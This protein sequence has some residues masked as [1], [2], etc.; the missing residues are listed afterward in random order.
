MIHEFKIGSAKTQITQGNWDD[1]TGRVT[2]VQDTGECVSL[3]KEHADRFMQIWRDLW[4]ADLNQTKQRLNTLIA[5]EEWSIR[6][7]EMAWNAIGG[8]HHAPLTGEAHQSK[9]Q[10]KHATQQRWYAAIVR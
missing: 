4:D 2:L 10:V 7:P 1:Q 5:M 9:I 8:L 6:D 3:S